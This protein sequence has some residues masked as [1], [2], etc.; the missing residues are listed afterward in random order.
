MRG[1]IGWT[2]K[3]N[4]E[5]TLEILITTLVLITAGNSFTRSTWKRF[6]LRVPLI[7]ITSLNAKGTHSIFKRLCVQRVTAAA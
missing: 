2:S 5:S 1:G 7:T 6:S 3:L 4:P